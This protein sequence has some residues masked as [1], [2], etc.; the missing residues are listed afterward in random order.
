M[1]SK[2]DAATLK[3]LSPLLDEALD[4]DEAQLEAW[5]V[6]RTTSS[7]ELAPI[8]REIFANESRQEIARLLEKRPHDLIAEP[9]RARPAWEFRP[10]ETIGPYTLVE[11]LAR[12]GMGE[13]WRAES[14]QEGSG[15]EVAL[16]LPILSL[17]RDVLVRRFERECEILRSLS[18]P[19][20]AR[21]F[22]AGVARE[23]QPYLALEYVEGDSITGY[24]TLNRLALAE[25]VHL[26]RQVMD[27]VQHAH[28]K[29]VIHRDLKPSNVLVTAE[30]K[31]MLLDF[32]IAKLVEE[33]GGEAHET[34]LTRVGGRALTLSYAAPEQIVG[35]PVSAQ[36][37]VW[38]LGVLLHELATG[39][40]P[41]GRGQGDVAHEILALE[42]TRPSASG[43][44]LIAAMPATA[45]TSLDTLVL[46]AL[47]KNPR[48]RYSS[49]AA[50]ADDID[51]WLA[52]RSVK[53]LPGGVRSPGSDWIARYAREAA[54]VTA[55]LVLVGGSL[56]YV[57][58]QS[59]MPLI[60]PATAS[61][62]L[63]IAVLPFS[64]LTG[65][66][67][68]AYVA[69][70]LTADITSD[71]A[72]IEDAVVAPITSALAYKDKPA[73]LAD[74]AKTLGVRFVLQGNVQ[75]SG[76]NVRINAQLHDAS[77][78]AQLWSEAFDGDLADL[79]ALQD[80]VTAR[81]S[82]SVG[83]KVVEVAARES[84]GRK[85]SPQLADLLLRARALENHHHTAANLEEGE[86]LY[87]QALA[88][89]PQ[90]VSAMLGLA[91]ALA[92]HAIN[93]T[94]PATEAAAERRTTE[95][96]ELTLK[97]RS[98]APGN[99]EVFRVMGYVAA[100]RGDSEGNRIAKETYLAT[101]PRSASANN[102]LGVWYFYAA[103]PRKAIPLLEKSLELTPNHLSDTSAFNLGRAYFML[104]DDARAIQ[105]FRRSHEIN[106][107]RTPGTS[108]WLAMAYAR[109]GQ[110]ALARE[111]AA[112]FVK[113]RPK[114]RLSSADGLN[115]SALP[116]FKRW[117]ETERVPAWRKAGLPE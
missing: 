82:N 58:R 84:E 5:L 26:L 40:L 8:L 66:A 64:N 69:E 76:T 89:D 60:A 109:S 72:R 77:S 65:D 30:G 12:G 7:P 55:V 100:R 9:G 1:T 62:A 20:I 113:A 117:H 85:D 102:G 50:F 22:E 51:R 87:R 14:R 103:E 35:N 70:A 63:T 23:G 108:D 56:G 34:D 92:M 95:A 114:A 88:L 53:A 59:W 19:N 42:P 57:T 18:H 112:A 94:T 111:A 90:S 24:A 38:A 27:A 80:K 78:G 106:P 28:E 43:S 32:G 86:A 93:F 17:R 68:Q 3:R 41:F 97:I 96:H 48:E 67:A 10:G 79:L 15:R 71:L 4:L 45:T 81:I 37:D 2:L 73:P 105:W 33:D 11:A 75:R 31:A 13:V 39:A 115:K 49:V 98:I 46:N 36:T 52:G 91:N 16:K 21:L 44:E 107:N 29:L 110:D 101:H 25:R 47:R 99:T 116:A 61:K 54:L 104:G 74:I 83:S 6:E